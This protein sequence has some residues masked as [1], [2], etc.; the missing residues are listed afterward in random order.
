MLQG[1]RWYHKEYTPERRVN[2]S[3]HRVVKEYNNLTTNKKEPY[4]RD[5]VERRVDG[6]NIP[7]CC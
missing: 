1:R 6:L 7:G 2:L 3:P 5:D 4:V